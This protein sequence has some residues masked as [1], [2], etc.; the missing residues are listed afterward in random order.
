[1]SKNQNQ[2]TG[3]RTVEGKARSSMNALKSGIYSKSLV[4]PS[5][6]PADLATLIDEYYERYRPFTP[7]QRDQVDILVRSTW[8]LRRLAVSETQVW[9]Y[10]LAA[11]YK[12]SES[13][14]LGQA[15]R[16]C[17]HT[18]TRL[19]RMVSSTQRSY[20]DALRE[21]ERLQSLHP[22][23]DPQE[24]VSYEPQP[25]PEP[26]S[27]PQP[28]ETKPVNQ[29]EENLAERTEE[30]PETRG[31]HLRPDCHYDPID[32]TLYKYCPMCAQAAG[33]KLR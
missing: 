12:P 24:S 18:L 31:Y 25:Q 30:T 33:Q 13:A 27:A 3:P 2:S 5:E 14:P 22:D 23:I 15:F 19:Y 4:I 32:P 7:E 10:E 11:A 28:E 6:D 26:Q 20:R 1:M 29:P 8:A 9:I 21:L 17:D 16:K